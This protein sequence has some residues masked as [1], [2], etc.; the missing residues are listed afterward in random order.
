MRTRVVLLRLNQ[1]RFPSVFGNC[2]SH[3]EHIFGGTQPVGLQRAFPPDT[4]CAG[5]C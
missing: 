2:L 3:W 5:L 1:D 4:I